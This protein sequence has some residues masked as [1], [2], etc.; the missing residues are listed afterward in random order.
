[1]SSDK[2][3]KS[4]GVWEKTPDGELVKKEGGLPAKPVEPPAPPAPPADVQDDEEEMED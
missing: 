4:G 3:P 1:M 2:R